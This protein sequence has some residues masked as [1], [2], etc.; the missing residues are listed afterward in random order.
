MT[1]LKQKYMKNTTY[2]L[3]L[4]L[5]AFLPSLQAQRIGDLNGIYY[6]AVAIDE[7]GKEIVGK[8]VEGKPLYN[9]AIGVRFTITKGLNGTIQWEET[10]TTNTDA[11]GL[12]SLIIG[13]GNRTPNSTYTKL[14]DIPWIDADQF[15][16]VEISSRNDSI[17][18]LVSNQQFMSVPYAFYSD[19]IAD[20]AITTEKVRDLEIRNQDIANETIDLTAKVTKV[21]PVKNGGTGRA[22]LPVN[23]LIVGQGTA[24]V[25]PIGAATNGQ[26][27]IGVTDDAPVLANIKAGKGIIVTNGPG[28]IE[29]SAG[30]VSTG[31]LNIGTISNQQ[32]FTSPPITVQGVNLGNIVVAAL[33][34]D[35]RG[36][37]MS[38]YVI[39]PNTI[40]VN[41]FNASGQGVFLGNPTLK[42]WVVQ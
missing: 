42:I 12:F 37:I 24:D 36:C 28:S 10:H 18:R 9:K 22:V 35:L 5:L 3:I 32:A 15:L 14:L 8:D 7:Y 21:L 33:D 30:G 6:Q 29:I 11:Y 19:D 4:L 41:I 20:D 2:M 23:S 17:Y 16:K 1:Q 38:A 27:P 25:R 13:K 40:R 26:I 31:T 34:T 39:S